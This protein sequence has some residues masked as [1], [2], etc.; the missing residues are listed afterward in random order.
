MLAQ[1]AFE[2]RSF[3]Q[4]WLL[5]ECTAVLG[6]I[7]ASG[8][9]QATMGAAAVA[10]L[11]AAFA[12]CTVLAPLPLRV[13]RGHV[14]KPKENVVLMPT[15]LFSKPVRCCEPDADRACLKASRGTRSLTR[16]WG[17]SYVCAMNS[18]AYGWKRSPVCQA[19]VIEM[20]GW[21][22]NTVC[23]ACTCSLRC[24]SPVCRKCP[25]GDFIDA[26]PASDTGVHCNRRAGGRRWRARPGSTTLDTV[27]NAETLKRYHGLKAAMRM[28]TTQV[29]L[30]HV[31]WWTAEVLW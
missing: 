20:R 11:S 23:R 19:C 2:G 9:S 29:R 18:S 6:R 4:A 30:R 14:H 5:A 31:H 17:T 15:C 16:G 21:L 27:R 3:D 10:G 12:A 8:K 26:R 13:M 24:L 25:K 28:L 7:A 22:S 1:G